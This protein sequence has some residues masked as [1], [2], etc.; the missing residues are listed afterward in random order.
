MVKF[1]DQC[2][3]CPAEMGCMG[4]SCPYMNVPIFI[5]DV[6]ES[7]VLYKDIR[8]IDGQHICRDCYMDKCETEFNNSNEVD[9]DN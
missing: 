3:G 1:E 4:N 6:C 7:K 8:D 9:Y 5:C 2:V